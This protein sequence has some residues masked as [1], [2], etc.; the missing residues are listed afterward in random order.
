MNIN[1]VE[2]ATNRFNGFDALQTHSPGLDIKPYLIV[3]VHFDVTSSNR[4][5]FIHL[6]L[7]Y[8]ISP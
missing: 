3:F 5:F 7:A 4:T 8:N 2:Q 1:I 6:Y